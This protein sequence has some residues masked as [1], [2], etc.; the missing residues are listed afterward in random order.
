MYQASIGGTVGRSR[1]T[2]IKTM[3]M[4][5]PKM[6]LRNLLRGG[7]FTE[8]SSLTGLRE[9]RCSISNAEVIALEPHVA[10][11]EVPSAFVAPQAVHTQ[12]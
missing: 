4:H 3:T 1:N 6:N 7:A 12:L 9:A 10:H 11:L 2:P 8:G 5:V